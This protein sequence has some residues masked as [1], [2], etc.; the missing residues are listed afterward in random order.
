MKTKM[1][2]LQGQDNIRNKICI[3]NRV[4]ERVNCFKHPSYFITHL[5]GE[6]CKL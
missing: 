5:N 1:T 4:T 6:D 3:Y 2:A